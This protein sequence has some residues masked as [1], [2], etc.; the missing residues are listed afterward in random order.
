MALP[1]EV[2]QMRARVC[3]DCRSVLQPIPGAPGAYRCP[4][5][6]GEWLRNETEQDAGPPP[7]TGGEARRPPSGLYL[8][9][10]V[11]FADADRFNQADRSYF[12]DLIASCGWFGQIGWVPQASQAGDGRLQ[13]GPSEKGGGSKSGRKRKKQPK[14]RPRPLA[15][16]Q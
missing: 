15:D 10:S 3:P 7:T 12:K 5:G 8:A 11:R 14:K 4:H 1:L 2:Q 9:Q 13:P 16:Y 6:H